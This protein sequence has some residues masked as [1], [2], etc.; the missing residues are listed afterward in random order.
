MY[1]SPCR[2]GVVARNTSAER[3]GDVVRNTLTRPNSLLSSFVIVNDGSNEPAHFDC[4]AAWPDCHAAWYYGAP[5]DCHVLVD[6]HALVNCHALI[7]CHAA[8]LDCHAAW[9]D[10]YAAWFDCHAAGYDCH[11]AGYLRVNKKPAAV[12]CRFLFSRSSVELW[13]N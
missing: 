13:Y 8:W 2:S 1:W 6:C 5:I 9:Y 7:D 12:F 11:A 10:C 3:Q 4:H